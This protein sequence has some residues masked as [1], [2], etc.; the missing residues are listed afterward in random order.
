LYNK[1]SKA[2]SGSIIPRLAI[3]WISFSTASLLARGIL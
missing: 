1:S 2:L 3:S